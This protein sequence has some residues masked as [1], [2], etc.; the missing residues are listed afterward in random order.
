MRPMVYFIE[1]EVLGVPLPPVP[2]L[3]TPIHAHI[4]CLKLNCDVATETLKMKKSI[5]QPCKTSLLHI[6]SGS[7]FLYTFIA[8]QIQILIA[9]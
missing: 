7:K 9:T 4:S 3:N 8:C 6:G 5:A 1:R 2:Q